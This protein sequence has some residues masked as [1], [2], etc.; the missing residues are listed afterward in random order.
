MLIPPRLEAQFGFGCGGEI[1]TTPSCRCATKEIGVPDDLENTKKD[2]LGMR[3]IERLVKQ[4]A[5]AW[6]I[7]AVQPGVEFMVAIP[8]PEG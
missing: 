3:L 1:T 8:S 4:A 7:G 2:Q 6:R 5:A